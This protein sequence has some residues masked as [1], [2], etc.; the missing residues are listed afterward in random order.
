[1]IKIT[2]KRVAALVAAGVIATTGGVAYSYWTTTGSGDGSGST[3]AGAGELSVEG[4]VAVAMFPGDQE[5]DLTVTVT[6]D[7]P[8]ATN[9]V[10][11][12]NAWITTDKA[13]CTGDD[14]LINGVA[15]PSTQNGAVAL[16]WTPQ[17][18]GAGLSAD[19][20]NTAQFNNKGDANQNACKGATV[21]F[22]YVA[23]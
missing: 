22:N 18:I 20:E 13:G 6:N 5:Q 19:S 23:G 17:Q 10:S 1:M 2:K 8:V 14:F 4:D 11:Y 21:T 9:L 16:T 12:V 3:A 15:A 7:D